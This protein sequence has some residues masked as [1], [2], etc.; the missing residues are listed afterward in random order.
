MTCRNQQDT[1]LLSGRGAGTV[2]GNLAHRQAVGAQLGQFN[3]GF[4]N[5][6]L[7]VPAL[8]GRYE[9]DPQPVLGDFDSA[10]IDAGTGR[11]GQGDRHHILGLDVMDYAKQD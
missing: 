11:T 10:C 8:H 4:L 9:A 5:Q 7:A 1:R 2:H 6:G 3:R